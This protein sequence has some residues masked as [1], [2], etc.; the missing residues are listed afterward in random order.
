MSDLKIACPKCNHPFELTE[1]LAG[2]MLEAERR[3]AREEAEQS[4]ASRT[5]AA[6]ALALEKARAEAAATIAILE[7]QR[8][9]AHAEVAKARDAELAALKVKQEAE[10]AKLAIDVEVARRVA[11]QAVLRVGI[12]AHQAVPEALLRQPSRLEGERAKRRGAVAQLDLAVGEVVD[13]AQPPQLAAAAR[14]VALLH[15]PGARV[16]GEL[17]ALASGV[18]HCARATRRVVAIGLLDVAVGGVD[19]RRQATGRVAEPRG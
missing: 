6:V 18:D 10:D 7:Q 1:A 2:R 9:A 19:D 14:H 8:Q 13:E 16:P 3:K 11:E 15:G 5:D 4:V 17:Q 12:A